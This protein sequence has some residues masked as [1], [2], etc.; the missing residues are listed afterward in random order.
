MQVALKV[1]DRNMGRPAKLVREL[2][3]VSERTTAR[4]VIRR[5]IEVEATELNRAAAGEINSTAL[6]DSLV[7]PSLVEMALNGNRRYGFRRNPAR[8]AAKVIEV[9][10]QLRIALEAFEKGSFIMLFDG[11]QIT[12]PDEE[13]TLAESSSV[14][15]IKLTPLV[16]G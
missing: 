16:G 14:T 13:L 3:L 15:F 6:A 4:D 11:R 5:R 2:R 10:E 8:A 7:V 12:M 9:E 1:F